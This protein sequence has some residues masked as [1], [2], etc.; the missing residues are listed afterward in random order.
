[1]GGAFLSGRLGLK[2]PVFFWA[3]ALS[4]C[5]VSIPSLLC[6]FLSIKWGKLCRTISYI[7]IKYLK[8]L[9][10]FTGDAGEKEDVI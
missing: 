7:S 4:C 3:V 5:H 9:D 1:M 6:S 8:C 2:L 10:R